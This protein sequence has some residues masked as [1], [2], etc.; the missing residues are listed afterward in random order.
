[1]WAPFFFFTEKAP[2]QLLQDQTE[3]TQEPFRISFFSMAI[4]RTQWAVFL[5][6]TGLTICMIFLGGG[7]G[8][9]VDLRQPNVEILSYALAESAGTSFIC[10]L[11][12][13]ACAIGDL[14]QKKSRNIGWLLCSLASILIVF[15]VKNVL[16]E[17]KP[18][19]TR[20][21]TKS[22]P[23]PTNKKDPKNFI[24]GVYK[25]TAPPDFAYP[26]TSTMTLS[27]DG[28]FRYDMSLSGG[29]MA[30]FLGTWSYFR[31]R[32]IAVT[33][34]R[35]LEGTPYPSTDESG[36]KAGHQMNLYIDG[37]KLRKENSKEY[38]YK[39]TLLIDNQSIAVIDIKKALAAEG[40]AVAQFELGRCY[41]RGEGV[42]KNQIEAV[43]WF[44]KAAEQGVDEAQFNLAYRY[45]SGLGVAK[46]FVEAYAYMNLAGITME[47][48]RKSLIGLEGEISPEQVAAGQRRTK[49]LQAEIFA[50]SRRK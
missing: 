10:L 26:G 48:A 33:N 40:D 27:S 22:A 34:E 46:D 9:S 12:Y 17:H 42:D 18:S 4:D 50:K 20:A 37:D 30:T 7:E 13:I 5:V 1:M 11:T 16:H 41:A 23:K 15:M 29:K 14:F 38:F 45:Y 21:V 3:W 47:A 36:W 19:I 6:S 31:D 32:V 28:K 43:G 25:Y 8:F 44:R 24:A 2:W 49:E 35:F 39:E